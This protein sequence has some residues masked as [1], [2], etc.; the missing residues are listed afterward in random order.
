MHRKPGK[1]LHEGTGS[2]GS[3]GPSGRCARGHFTLALH[4]CPWCLADGREKGTV[5]AMGNEAQKEA[6][7]GLRKRKPNTSAALKEFWKRKKGLA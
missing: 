6:F 2:P 5:T 3:A 4:H 7:I 1:P